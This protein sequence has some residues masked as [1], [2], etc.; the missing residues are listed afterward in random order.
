V[1]IRA[2]AAALGI[3][4]AALAVA[5]AASLVR[6]VPV[7]RQV[8]ERFGSRPGLAGDFEKVRARVAL[9]PSYRA[10][11]DRH[12]VRAA[13]ILD[14]GSVRLEIDLRAL[15]RP[16]LQRIGWPE[17]EDALP[18]NATATIAT[19]DSGITESWWFACPGGCVLDAFATKGDDATTAPR[20]IPGEPYATAT[21]RLSPAR[22][23]DLAIGGRARVTLAQR[24]DLVEQILGRPVR[25]TLSEDLAGPGIVAVYHTP[26]GQDRT[27]LAFELKRAD[28]LRGLVDLTIG[29]GALTRGATVTRYRDVAIGSW[30]GA[31]G[32][33]LAVAIDGPLLLV[34]PDPGRIEDA[35]DRRR[36]ETTTEGAARGTGD[37]GTA[38]VHL[39]GSDGLE[40]RLTREAAGW[41]L[42]ASG[43]RPLVESDVLSA[44]LAA[45]RR[46]RQRAGG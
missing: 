16:S 39:E 13:R 19:V 29:L 40:A 25:A 5:Y 24:A 44:W 8:P 34:A 26:D 17:L 7:P 45:L 2:V 41:R 3:L 18:S 4:A 14:D 15:A 28:R 27:L 43:P 36:D 12:A 32:G 21:F 20:A 10:C 11:F 1:T 37:P 23:A 31:V 46:G 9:F 42:D 22:I 33:G 6:P 30:S 38:G 35:I